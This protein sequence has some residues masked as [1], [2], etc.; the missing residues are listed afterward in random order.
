M[1]GEG[2]EPAQ[3]GGGQK[4]SP[5]SAP[6]V[7]AKK[8]YYIYKNTS[9]GS[10][11]PPARQLR[12]RGQQHPNNSGIFS[13]GHP[14]R[15]AGTH[16]CAAPR[17]PFSPCVDAFVRVGARRTRPVTRGVRGRGQILAARG[18]CSAGTDPDTRGEEQ[19]SVG[20]ARGLRQG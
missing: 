12:L 19:R 7:N 8:N 4:K 5:R 17:P 20:S 18:Y 15:R 3:S 11:N 6:G 10:S 13:K 9:T 1:P 16:A 14:G 2:A